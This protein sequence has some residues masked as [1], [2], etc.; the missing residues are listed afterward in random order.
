M[1]AINQRFPFRSTPI[2]DLL[3]S[4]IGIGDSV[5]FFAIHQFYWK[6]P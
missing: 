4:I 2:L 6:S 3:L 1:F 5:V